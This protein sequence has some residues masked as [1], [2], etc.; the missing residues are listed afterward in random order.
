MKKFIPG[1][2]VTVITTF[3]G[4]FMVGQLNDFKA[5]DFLKA[6]LPS[7]RFLCAAVITATST[8]LALILTLISFSNQ[9]E[10]EIH[11]KHYTRIKDIAK[12]ST[13]AFIM[14]IVL[15][16]FINL[17]LE[18][19]SDKLM[20]WFEIIYYIVL[21]AVSILGGLLITIVLMLY[22]AAVEIILIADP[23]GEAN[24]LIKSKEEEQEESAKNE[25]SKE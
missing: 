11:T 14:A 20:V 5:F 23:E 21:V 12:L 9:T 4:V 25:S 6:M 13:G 10:K 2:L 18:N 3:F 19:A 24:L 1:I 8:V 17:P 7:T 15:L 22:K 16:L